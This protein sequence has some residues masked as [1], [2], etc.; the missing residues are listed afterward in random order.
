MMN[1][2]YK[3]DFDE[4]AWLNHTHALVPH[5]L[6]LTVLPMWAKDIVQERLLNAPTKKQQDSWDYLVEICYSADNWEKHKDAFQDFTRTLDKARGENFA[7]VIP[8][9]KDMLI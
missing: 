3:N 6:N 7:S 2:Y 5:H 8:E 1:K 9:F 4:T